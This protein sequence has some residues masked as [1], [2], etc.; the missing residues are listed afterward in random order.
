M[1][2]GLSPMLSKVEELLGSARVPRPRG[3][4]T[5][6]VGWVLRDDAS[7]RGFRRSAAERNL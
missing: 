6:P 7:R 5:P 1:R 3:A 2:R 4:R